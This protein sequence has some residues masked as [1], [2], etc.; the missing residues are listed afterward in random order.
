MAAFTKMVNGEPMSIQDL[1]RIITVI[2]SKPLQVAQVDPAT[3]NG[4]QARLR[5]AL[6]TYNRPAQ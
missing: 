4:V 3:V 2:A 1:D 5:D 6:A